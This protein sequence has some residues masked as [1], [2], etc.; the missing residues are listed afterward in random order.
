MSSHST[1]EYNK[2]WREAH[3]GANKK[4]KE[5]HPEY[6]KE[7][8]SS[9]PERKVYNN[10][11]RK[12]HPEVGLKYRKTHKKEAAAYYYE[13]SHHE[14]IENKVARLEAQGYKCANQACLRPI[15]LTI[16]HQDHDHETGEKRGVLCGDC[17]RALG[18][19]KDQAE[20]VE[21]LANYRRLF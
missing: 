17:N 16:G 14:K 11:W 5:A 13:Y 7:Y 12:N 18:L 1:P 2:K 15:D 8:Y 9:H 4:W 10:E 21:G 6:D 20:I 19:L 3:P